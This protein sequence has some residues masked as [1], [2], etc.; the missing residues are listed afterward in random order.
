M[1]FHE[2][3]KKKKKKGGN[4]L[5]STLIDQSCVFF[6]FLSNCKPELNGILS[7]GLSYQLPHVNVV[8]VAVVDDQPTFLAPSSRTTLAFSPLHRGHDSISIV[9]V[10]GSIV[11]Y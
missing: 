5:P 11:K 2:H 10:R 3:E 1:C 8:V 7:G 6:C 9:I 4:N